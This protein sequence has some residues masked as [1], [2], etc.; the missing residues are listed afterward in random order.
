[1]T[2]NDIRL[3][4]DCANKH[5]TITIDATEHIFPVISSPRC[6]KCNWSGYC[7]EHN[8]LVE[9]TLNRQSLQKR[10]LARR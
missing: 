3:A 5:T 1:M 9:R 4:D 6:I 2:L 7:I 8:T 10:V